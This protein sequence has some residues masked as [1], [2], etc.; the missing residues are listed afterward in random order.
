MGLLLL[1]QHTSPALQSKIQALSCT[2]Q[3]AGDARSHALQG[4]DKLSAQT[5]DTTLDAADPL[6][7]I[8]IKDL[9]IDAGG[10][11]TV[12]DSGVVVV[13]V[14]LAGGRSKSG[15]FRR[16]DRQRSL[17]VFGGDGGNGEDR[18]WANKDVGKLVAALQMLHCGMGSARQVVGQGRIVSRP[19]DGWQLS[20]CLCDGIDSTRR[21]SGSLGGLVRPEVLDDTDRDLENASLDGL[22]LDVRS[23]LLVHFL[24][25]LG[26]LS[27][28]GG[29]FHGLQVVVL[30][31]DHQRRCADEG[32]ILP[33]EL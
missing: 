15:F 16:Q 4:H 24:E 17:H 28:D 25:G 26:Q 20:G 10:E 11:K 33:Q 1:L 13:W 12:L 32:G 18:D 7:L 5:I 2:L 3:R 30:K 23:N 21:L 27:S 6:G 9:A 19:G 31:D 29:P 22:Q 8:D 14:T